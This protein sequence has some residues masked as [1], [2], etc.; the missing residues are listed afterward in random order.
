MVIAI[1]SVIGLNFFQARK[2]NA[3]LVKEAKYFFG[4]M[5]TFVIIGARIS[6]DEDMYGKQ[7]ISERF[8]RPSECTQ[9]EIDKQL[10]ERDPI[11][12]ET[13]SWVVKGVPIGSV[14]YS[15]VGNDDTG[16]YIGPYQVKLEFD[17]RS[18]GGIVP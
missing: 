16:T 18:V 13:C 10:E 11:Y 2:D 9:T 5:E 7:A 17:R 6:I 3:K 14:G 8:G 4:N 12:A 15:Y 1:S